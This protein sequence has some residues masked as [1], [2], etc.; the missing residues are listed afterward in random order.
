MVIRE[1]R[2]TTQYGAIAEKTQKISVRNNTRLL[3][4]LWRNK[5]ETIEGK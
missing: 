4:K 2:I 1:F 3:P 5:I